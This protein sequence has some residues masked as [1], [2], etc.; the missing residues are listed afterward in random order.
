MM[1]LIKA[2]IPTYRIG[3]HHSNFGYIGINTIIATIINVMAT[4]SMA[5]K[6]N[7]PKARPVRSLN[8][9]KILSG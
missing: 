8:H 3:C 6:C 5:N 9:S 2:S 1:A 4:A 7:Q